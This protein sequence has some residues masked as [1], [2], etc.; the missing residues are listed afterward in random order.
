MDWMEPSA[1]FSYEITA[2]P[3]SILKYLNLARRR[4]LRLHRTNT[5][6]TS[7]RSLVPKC[8]RYP[9]NSLLI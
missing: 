1:G 2:N 7:I 3:S 8:N 4:S 5:P 6:L 9:Q